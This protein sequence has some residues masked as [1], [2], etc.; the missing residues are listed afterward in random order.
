MKPDPRTLA[1][2]IAETERRMI[3]RALAESPSRTE[4]AAALGITRRQLYRRLAALFTADE[5]EQL[6]KE[7]KT[8]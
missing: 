8:K 5:I 2:G 7:E 3:L 4:A 6:G 1:E